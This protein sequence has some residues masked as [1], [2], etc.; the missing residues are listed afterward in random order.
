MA[1]QSSR[2]PPAIRATSSNQSSLPLHLRIVRF[3][4]FR[5]WHTRLLPHPTRQ[6]LPQTLPVVTTG[7]GCPHARR[8]KGAPPCSVQRDHAF[9]FRGQQGVAG[10]APNRP[11]GLSVA[12]ASAGASAGDPP[13]P[14]PLCGIGRGSYGRNGS[15]FRKSLTTL[16]IYNIY[17]FFVGTSRHFFLFSLF[18]FSP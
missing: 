14:P 18:I 13:A 1:G 4:S 5:H 6:R 9:R 12:G 2:D 16:K 15:L 7:S 17:F 8:P 10:E 3:D 11:A